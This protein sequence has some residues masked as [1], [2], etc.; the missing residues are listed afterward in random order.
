MDLLTYA[1]STITSPTFSEVIVFYREY[2]LRAE[3][4]PRPGGS[5]FDLWVS[6]AEIVELALSHHRRFEGLRMMHKVRKFRLVLCVDV[7]DG[8]VGC[9]MR[10]LKRAIAAEKAKNG[11]SDIFLEPLVFYSLQRTRDDSHNRASL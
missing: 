1:L 4:L 7:W 11:F 3:P 9:C 10:T 2:D 5:L 6:P 8:M